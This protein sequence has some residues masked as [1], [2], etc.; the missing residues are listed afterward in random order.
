MA[1][2]ANVSTATVS[3]AL[4]GAPTVAPELAS[5][6]RQAAARLGYR[7]NEAARALAS[8]R[9]RNVAVTIPDATNPYFFAVIHSLLA[10][11]RRQGYGVLVADAGGDPAEE[12]AVASGLVGQVDGLVLLASRLEREDLRTL[13]DQ[14]APVVLG[15]RLELGIALPMVAVDIFRAMT[16]LCGHL[17][18]LGHRRVAYLGGSPLSWQDQER[19]RAV[20][21]ASAFGVESVRLVG[22]GSIESGREAVDE[23]LRHRPTA[24]VCFNDLTAFGA[25]SRLRELGLGVP[26]D[27][28]VTGF[29]DVELARYGEVAL[30]TAA[31]PT[32]RLGELLWRAIDP[33]APSHQEAPVLLDAPVI[34]RSS[35]GAPRR[36]RRTS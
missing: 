18:E 11:A 28:S 21:Q 4:S 13:A 19:W 35:T 14:G 27:L 25:I 33:L 5:R 2:A 12:R 32:A 24:L 10:S 6:V 22:R 26:E 31:S 30:T 23:A 17:A 3:R 1:A 29:D 34:V 36:R 8:G 9:R 16:R 15:N 7:P 20:T